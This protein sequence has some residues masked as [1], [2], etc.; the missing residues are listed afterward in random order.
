M[1]LLLSP[2]G[3][4][5]KLNVVQHAFGAAIQTVGKSYKYFY[6]KLMLVGD[7]GVAAPAGAKTRW[8]GLT[9]RQRLHDAF[10]FLLQ[11]EW[12]EQMN[13]NYITLRLPVKQINY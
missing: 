10:M 8:P 12:R 9:G 4:L 3:I 11:R 5:P 13:S 6:F 2:Q 7:E 1:S